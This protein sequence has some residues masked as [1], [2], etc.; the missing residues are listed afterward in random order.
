MDGHRNRFGLGSGSFEWRSLVHR[1]KRPSSK[2]NYCTTLTCWVKL[3]VLPIE[4]RPSPLCS[5]GRSSCTTV[6]Q[7]SLCSGPG[8]VLLHCCS[9]YVKHDEECPT[10]T[11]STS[12]RGI[13]S[14]SKLEPGKVVI[15]CNNRFFQPGKRSAALCTC[16]RDPSVMLVG[17]RG[18][19]RPES[20]VHPV[21]ST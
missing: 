4:G 1:A 10:R 8:Q 19:Q 12:T 9:T 17:I 18:L 13:K 7:F 16:K 21:S 11:P 6:H 2:P 3:L 5:T 15:T 20:H 14:V